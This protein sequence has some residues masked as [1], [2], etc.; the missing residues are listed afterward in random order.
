MGN[1]KVKSGELVVEINARWEDDGVGVVCPGGNFRIEW[2]GWESI[3]ANLM[4]GFAAGRYRIEHLFGLPEGTLKA[5]TFTKCETGEWACSWFASVDAMP[6]EM[7]D[8]VYADPSLIEVLADGG[9]D[10]W[11][12]MPELLEELYA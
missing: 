4:R 3:S 7:R 8:E 2:D 5:S 1:A 10:Y 12:A 11:S 9:D 6:R